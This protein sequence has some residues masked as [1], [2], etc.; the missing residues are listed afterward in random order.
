M[1]CTFG[2]PYSLCQPIRVRQQHTI[3]RTG[4]AGA[5]FNATLSSDYGVQK[6]VGHPLAGAPERY[7][8]QHIGK[9]SPA[10]HVYHHYA[11]G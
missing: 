5:E 4:P 8:A 7:T 9:L 11:R 3:V 1:R 2:G 10:V 6:P